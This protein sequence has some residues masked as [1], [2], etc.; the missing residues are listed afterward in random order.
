VRIAAIS[1]LCTPQWRYLHT[2]RTFTNNNSNTDLFLGKH[3]RDKAGHVFLAEACRIGQLLGMFDS[4]SLRTSYEPSSLHQEKWNKIRA[5]TAWTLFNFQLY[6]SCCAMLHEF[7]WL[8]C[9][10]NMSFT[11][12]FPAIIRTLPSVPIPYE[13]STDKGK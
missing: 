13:N 7:V 4:R 5:V 8:T 3:G 11:Y 6:A 2:M 9:Y 1:L 10:R 12:C